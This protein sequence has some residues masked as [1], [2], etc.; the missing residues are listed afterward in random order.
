MKTK[1]IPPNL[2]SISINS[3]CD[4]K[5]FEKFINTQ[6]AT[7]QHLQFITSKYRV[8]FIVRFKIFELGFWR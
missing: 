7:Q 3:F 6:A 8:P 2:K 4:Q 1:N 5:K